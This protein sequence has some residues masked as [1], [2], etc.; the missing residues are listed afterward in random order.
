MAGSE[1]PLL[2]NSSSDKQ[3]MLGALMAALRNQELHSDQLLPAIVE[4]F[5]RENNT[6]TIRPLIQWVDVNDETHTRHS[7]AKINV[8]SLGGGGFHISFPIKAGDLGWI[9]A[10]DRDISLFKQSLK[11]SKPNTG[12]LHKFEDGWFI[13]DVL[14]QYSIAEEDSNALVIQS[15]NSATRI[16]ISNGIVNITAP[17]SVKVDTPDATFTGNVRVNGDVN[18]DGTT[19]VQTDFNVTGL[20]KVNGGFIAASGKP[21]TLPATTTVNGITVATHGHISSP[22]GTRTAGSMIT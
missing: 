16:S 12:R 9:L 7:F 21:C 2:A 13:P 1:T 22:A 11:E 19:N 10:S 8:L 3:R 4:S 6:A 5:D 14:R 20:S 18:V 15:T 17:T